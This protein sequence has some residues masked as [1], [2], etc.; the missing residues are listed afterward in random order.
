MAALQRIIL[1][2][3]SR[4]LGEVFH[5]ALYRVDELQVVSEVAAED[6]LPEA[7]GTT[8]ADWL[9]MS[10][11][12]DQGIPDWVDPYIAEHPSVRLLAVSEGGSNARIRW[13]EA[14]EEDLEDPSLN[15][16]I[17]ILESGPQQV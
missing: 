8:E 12:V 13:L 10:L 11:P 16:L 1:V 6:E 15:E 2:N 9:L 5:A 3:G 7:L 14:R 17:D 4:L